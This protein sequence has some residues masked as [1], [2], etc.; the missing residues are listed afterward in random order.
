LK[1]SCLR[2]HFLVLGLLALQ[3]VIAAPE[4][5][6]NS[7]G[8][9]QISTLKKNTSQGHSLAPYVF[10]KDLSTDTV[11]MDKDS[12]VRMPPSSMTKILTAYVI[13]KALKEGA[14]KLSDHFV[15]SPEAAKKEGSNMVLNPGQSVSIKDLL[16]GV[17]A[18]SGN[19]ACCVL[20][21]GLAG[22]E[23]GFC[24]LMNQEA[25]NL[26]AKNS[27]FKNASG[28]PD[29]EHWSTCRDLALFSEKTLQNFPQ[30]YKDYY[31]IQEFTFNKA[32]HLN[33]NL[34]LRNGFSDGFKTGKTDA[35]KCG[36]VAS[37]QRE[38]RRLLLVVNGIANEI[39][40]AQEARR[41]LDWGFSFFVPAI[42]A[43]PSK[44]FTSIAVKGGKADSIQLV[45]LKTAGIS[46]P[47]LLLN[48][49]QVKVEHFSHALAPVKKGQPMGRI[50]ILVPEKTPMVFTLV[51]DQDVAAL[52]FWDKIK[53][54]FHSAIK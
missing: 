33:R 9:P 51:A 14:L 23:E 37:S 7:S 48:K 28:L 46:L 49:G 30:E 19:N 53:H 5:H 50:Q 1:K 21:Q 15:V 52:S 41:L 31:A 32:K 45:T 34:L 8:N 43:S 20:A 26:G 35:G 10:L 54:F 39:L 22:S 38:G 16:I 42:V 4:K 12:E 2:Y 6:S 47:R 24:E 25:L 17:I 36:M 40:R 13:F 27:R 18:A 44:P 29:P 3:Q 11:L